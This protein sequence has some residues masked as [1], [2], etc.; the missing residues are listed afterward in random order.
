M[1][2]EEII[3]LLTF[4]R[5]YDARVTVGKAEVAAWFLAVNRVP[6]AIAEHA[7]TAHYTAA[8]E[9]GREYPRI[10]PGHVYA[11]WQSQ[12]RYQPQAVA[13]EA[14]KAS[15]AH[16]AK[17]RAQIDAAVEAA[18]AKFALNDAE[19]LNVPRWR[20]GMDKQELALR[21]VEATRRRRDAGGAA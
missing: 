6:L 11:H 14:P 16:A 12:L 10:A 13:I 20:P 7:V 18:S 8:V 4:A 19:P 1:T 17:C 15:P 3:D 5:V 21:Q 2:R 9:P